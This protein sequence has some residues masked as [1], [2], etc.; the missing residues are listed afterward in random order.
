M[1]GCEVE[2]VSFPLLTTPYSLLTAFTPHIP[3]HASTHTGGIFIIMY[4]YWEE[5]LKKEGLGLYRGAPAKYT[6]FFHPGEEVAFTSRVSHARDIRVDWRLLT[7]R[8]EE[9]IWRIFYDRQSEREA[10][11]QMGISRSSLRVHRNRALAKL[12]KKGG[13]V[14]IKMSDKKQVKIWRFSDKV[15]KGP[16]EEIECIDD[17]EIRKKAPRKKSKKR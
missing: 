1:I 12:K 5:R 9:V 10:A 14:E 4:Q 2:E 3:I 16:V 7:P 15:V 13:I 11:T 17:E 8:E 6:R